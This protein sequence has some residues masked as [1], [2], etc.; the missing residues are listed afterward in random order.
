MTERT[1]DRR[2]APTNETTRECDGVNRLKN[3][4]R[5]DGE[6]SLNQL[7]IWTEKYHVPT[8]ECFNWAQSVTSSHQ[9]HE[10]IERD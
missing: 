10:K 8:G 9:E 6:K 1:R 7:K 4:V 5:Y 3:K 2:W